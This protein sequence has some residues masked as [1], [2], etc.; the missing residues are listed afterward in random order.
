MTMKH[1]DAIVMLATEVMG[2]K[3]ALE[4]LNSPHEEFE[5][6]KPLDIWDEPGVAPKIERILLRMQ[7]NRAWFR[8]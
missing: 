4:W 8:F 3:A 6:K 5:G 1:R 7:V 2:A